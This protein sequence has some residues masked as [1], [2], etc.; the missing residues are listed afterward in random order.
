MDDDAVVEKLERIPAYNRDKKVA[1]EIKSGAKKPEEEES[2]A[3]VP[4]ED[5]KNENV[6]SGNVIEF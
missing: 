6:D 4:V 3:D 1:D 5:K 2:V